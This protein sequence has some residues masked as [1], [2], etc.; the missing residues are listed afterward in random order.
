MTRADRL[1]GAILGDDPDARWNAAGNAGASGAEA[2][3]RLAEVMGGS[4]PEKSKAARVA[5]DRIALAST[6]PGEEKERLAVSA[7]L[8]EVAAGQGPVAVR[9]H[10]IRLLGLAGGPEACATL[11]ALIEDSNLRED[12]R[13]ALHRIPGSAAERALEQAARRAP[14]GYA[15]ALVCSLKDRKLGRRDAGI[16]NRDGD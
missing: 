13:M 11:A 16:R 3:A 10:A 2:I 7:A 1:V 15:S 8:V 12:A 14:P 9:R 5:M 6:A 4:D